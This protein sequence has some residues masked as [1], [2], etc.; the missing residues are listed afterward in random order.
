MK[1]LQQLIYLIALSSWGLVGITF[2]AEKTAL[3]IG[4]QS[5][6]MKD[7][8][9]LFGSLS[10]PRNDAMDIAKVLRSYG[11]ATRVLLDVKPDAMLRAVRC[12]VGQSSRN[13]KP[14]WSIEKNG[15]A[16]FYYSGH[17][18]QAKI[19]GR[20]HNYL[21]PVGHLYADVADVKAHG[22]HA[23]WVLD[24]MQLSGSRVNV[25]ILDACRN[26]VGLSQAKGLPVNGFA[27]MY[28]EGAFVA[29]ATQ[30]GGIAWGNKD[31]RNSLFTEKLLTQLRLAGHSPIH[32]IFRKTRDAVY[33]TTKD[34]PTG[35]QIPW[36]EEKLIGD[37]CFSECRRGSQIE[38]KQTGDY[39]CDGVSAP[40]T[41]EITPY[42]KHIHSIG[43][44]YFNLDKLHTKY[45]GG[46]C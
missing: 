19:Q 36:E 39:A 28:P 45:S 31:D 34:Y 7:E 21:I 11:F 2:A 30:A 46:V 33:L 22:V 27:H 4:N 3:I 29:Y 44:P 40:D 15:Q 23:N 43:I 18:V 24:K 25:M 16:V 10:N 35:P 9:N 41:D 13:C 5:Y 17:G 6:P 37:F 1:K 14:H 38:S 42:R 12:F 8:H 26:R 20:F 32:E